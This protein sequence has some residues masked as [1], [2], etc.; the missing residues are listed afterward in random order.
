MK[1]DA[2]RA[3][4]TDRQRLWNLLMDP[5]FIRKSMPGCEDLRTV[6][7][8]KY[9]AVMKVGVGTVKGT[10]S[11]KIEISDKDPLSSYRLQA[12]GSGAAGF[13]KGGAMVRL[14]DQGD[15]KVLMSLQGE[16]QVGGPVARVGQRLLDIV[17][18]YMVNEF[19]KQIEKAIQS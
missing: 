5:A 13:V 3:F 15:G 17:S 6:E 12:E 7:P 2:S 4:A 1:I 19:F 9:E 16:A 14:A 8:D 18:R 11:G 10:Y